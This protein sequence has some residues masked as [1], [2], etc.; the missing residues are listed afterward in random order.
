MKIRCSHQNEELIRLY[1]EFYG[2]P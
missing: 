2:R 1:E